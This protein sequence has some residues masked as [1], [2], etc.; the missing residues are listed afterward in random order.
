M[1]IKPVVRFS[2][3]LF[4]EP[5]LTPTGFVACNKEDTLALCIESESDTPLTTRRTKADLFHIGVTGIVQ[6]VDAWTAQLGPE[7]L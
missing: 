4:I 6:C 5:L 7:L 2:D 3:E 1:G